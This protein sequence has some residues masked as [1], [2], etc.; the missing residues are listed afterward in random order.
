MN[1]FKRA[2]SSVLAFVMLCSCVMIA[3]VSTVMAADY[4]DRATATVSSDGKNK[5]WDYSKAANL[6]LKVGDT[7]DGIVVGASGTSTDRTRINSNALNVRATGIIKVPVPENSTGTISVVCTGNATDRLLTLEDDTF[8]TIPMSKSGNSVSFTT[9]HSNDG[10]LSLE[11]NGDYKIASLTVTLTSD[12]TFGAVT[13][14]TITGACTGLEAGTTFNLTN[15][16]TTYTATVNDDGTGYTV[17]STT[18]VD[19]T[20]TYT[21]SLNNY[22]VTYADSAT[23]ITIS[24]SDTTFTATPSI[25]FAQLSLGNLSEGTYGGT[26]I[27]NGLP[28]FEIAS[29]NGVGE[30]S[31]THYRIRGTMRFKLAQEATVVINARCASSESGKSVTMSLTDESGT[32]QSISYGETSATSVTLEAGGALT[33]YTLSLPAGTYTLTA[34]SSNTSLQIA[35]ITVTKATTE[36]T[37]ETTTEAATEATTEA[38]SGITY[39]G[40]NVIYGSYTSLITALTEDNGFYVNNCSTIEK[41]EVTLYSELDTTNNPDKNSYISF[42]LAD[43]ATMSFIVGNKDIAIYNSDNT[44]KETLGTGSATVTLNAGSYYVKSASTNESGSK[45]KIDSSTNFVVAKDGEIYYTVT[46]NATVDGTTVND[47][48]GLKETL[49][50]APIVTVNGAAFTVS[51][52]DSGVGYVSVPANAALKV[53]YT[54]GNY[55]MTAIDTTITGDTTITLVFTTQTSSDKPQYEGE[56]DTDGYYV[57]YAEVSGAKGIYDTIQAAVDAVELAGGNATIYIADG[58]YEEEVVVEGNGIKFQGQSMDVILTANNYEGKDGIDINFHNPTLCIKGTGFEATNMTIQ[59]TAED[60]GLTRKNA[61]AVSVGPDSGAT[62]GAA[63]TNCD[64][65]ATRDTFYTGSNSAD[66]T[67]TL[68]SCNIRGFQDVV[69]GSGEV[70]VENCTFSVN[71][72]IEARLFAPRASEGSNKTVFTVNNLT[73]T[74]STTRDTN[75]INLARPWISSDTKSEDNVIII[76]GYTTANTVAKTR[77]NRSIANDNMYGFEKDGVG[78]G[79][80]TDTTKDYWFLVKENESDTYY[81]TSYEDLPVYASATYVATHEVADEGQNNPAHRIVGTITNALAADSNVNEV[82]FN[83]YVG[84][85]LTTRV[86]DST[87]YKVIGDDTAI[88]TVNFIEDI[89]TDVT[90]VTAKA[91]V[92]YNGCEVE[93]VNNSYTV[94]FSQSSE[95]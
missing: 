19:T 10:Y 25:A 32:A 21:A 31:G 50:N 72:N 51:E 94:T 76:T 77:L 27:N 48:A 53:N 14:Y 44:I 1:N 63:F 23:G 20:G 34:D 42:N 13:T 16:T 86:S 80:T 87:V 57:G 36:S 7:V 5:T 85:T 70:T 30:I 82:G 95:Q 67:V 40:G 74:T 43:T 88:Y 2:L 33:D 39:P 91:Y 65:L 12:H 79:T 28:N 81:N 24:G 83:F 90:N 22:S 18:V 29:T 62:A 73:I 55:S 78:S 75:A 66:T 84:D 68:T 15:G 11:S 38:Q 60:E 26:V 54:H 17:T 47:W 8:L 6:S 45:I 59:N 49:G 41:R 37:T 52:N 61:P 92:L 35:S 69:C 64:I 46:F 9:S 58:R 89:P 93:D 3:N 4:V 56:V 71:S